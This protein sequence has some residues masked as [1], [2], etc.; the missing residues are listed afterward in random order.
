MKR[1]LTAAT[2]LLLVLTGCQ[3]QGTM[4]HGQVF[5]FGTTTIHLKAG[6]TFSLHKKLAVVPGNDWQVSD[7]RPDA[8]VVTVVGTDR[9]KADGASGDGGELYLIF[10]AVANGNTQVVLDNCLDCPPSL[11]QIYQS[12]DTYNVEVG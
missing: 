5:A 4:D 11:K 7:P 6:Q 8:K 10:K 2:G 1:A 3:S 12:H 9:I